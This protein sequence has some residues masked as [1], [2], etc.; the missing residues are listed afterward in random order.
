M[1]KARGPNK[2]TQTGKVSNNQ[3]NTDGLESAFAMET[4]NLKKRD[5]LYKVAQKRLEAQKLV[6]DGINKSMQASNNLSKEQI[7]KIQKAVN[8]WSEYESIQAKVLKDQK[9]GNLTAKGANKII[10]EYKKQYESALKGAK[11][12]GKENK[13]I[14]DVL[15]SLKGEMNLLDE[16]V[17]DTAKSMNLVDEALDEIGSSG[18]PM[19]RELTNI[20]KSAKNGGVGLTTALFAAGAALGALAY[21]YGLVGNKIK[22]AAGYDKRIAELSGN[23]NEINLQIEAGLIGPKNRRNFVVEKAAAEFASSMKQAAAAFQAASKTALFGESIGGVGYAADK[24]QMAGIGAE[25]IASSMSAAADATGRMPSGRVAADMAIMSART[26]ASEA[27]I[28]SINESFMRIDGLTERSSLN[29][30]EGLRAMAKSAKINLGGLVEEMAE[31]SKD[32]LGYQIKSTSILAKQVTFAK[33]LGVSFNAVAKAGQSMVL[34]Y[35]DSIKSEMQLSAM[36]G[37]NVDLSEVRAKFA[38]GDQTGALRALQAQGLDP[39]KMDMFQQQML[40]QATGMDLNTL[41]KLSKNRGVEANLSSGNAG[42]GNAGFLGRNVSAQATLNARNAMIS[43]ETAIQ[44]N[45]INRDEEMA[46][47]QGIVD[48]LGG[49]QVA[50]KELKQIEGLKD[51]EIGLTTAI[52]AL[53]GALALGGLGKLGEFIKNKAVNKTTTKV[54]EKATTKVVEKSASKGIGKIFS[55]GVAKRIP[56]LGSILGLG[57]AADRLMSGDFAGAGLETLSAGAG[58]LDLVAPGAGTASSLAID[59]G[60]AARDMGVFKGATPSSVAAQAKPTT[61]QVQSVTPANTS[62]T[63]TAANMDKWLKDKMVQMNGNLE[64]VVD[65]THKTMMNTATTNKELH[66]LNTNTTALK[67]LT[68]RIEALTRATYEGGTVVKIDGK[69]V[70]TAMDRYQSNTAGTNPTSTTPISRG[71]KTTYGY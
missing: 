1:A 29:M 33:S 44:L 13:Q 24:L 54:A 2:N 18:V 53:I 19:M 41:S 34:N 43:S 69:V 8:I 45:K 17:K 16:A 23:I 47:Q 5:E 32:M 30:Q 64:R 66:V 51:A 9:D 22:T 67:E 57:F 14:R 36:L 62:V 20:L 56:I 70:A 39:A 11:L 48:N 65:R 58:L 46:K 37:K 31:A 7:N 3:L 27:S 60:I 21:N 25:K 71:S 52:Y 10:S 6:V 63:T 59:A 42:R 61:A 12:F 68:R 28:A 15:R 50:M 4:Q 40:Q 55:K 49:I 26:G 38:S 35:K